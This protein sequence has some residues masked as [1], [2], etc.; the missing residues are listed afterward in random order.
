MRL[1]ALAFSLLALASLPAAE[2][3]RSAKVE[4]NRDVRPILA[5]NCFACHG[6]D[7]KHREAD[8]RLD[9]FEGATADRDGVRG[10]VPGD[11]SKSDVWQRLTSSDP[12]E[13]MPPPHSN[14]PPL[15]AA[16]REVLKQWIEQGAKYERHWSF[17]PPKRGTPPEV[18]GAAHPIDRF[19]QRRLAQEQLAPSPEA[20]ATTLIRR[21]SLDLTGLPPTLAE[22][23]AL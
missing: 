7:P 6:F 4:F 5:E 2:A 1:P 9:T 16:Q 13:V 23:D 14:K 15:T 19:I 21:V 20:D 10:V 11:L 8:L 22:V 12:D 3:T 17:E 18:A